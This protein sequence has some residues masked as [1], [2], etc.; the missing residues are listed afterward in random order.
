MR[1]RYY[2]SA[3]VSFCL[4]S[5]I[6]ILSMVSMYSEENKV[7]VIKENA[8]LKLKPS[9]ESLTI[10]RLPLG[11]EL[12]VVETIGEWIKIKLPPDEDGIV[13]T[14]YIH[15]SFVTFDIRPPQS[16]EDKRPTQLKEITKPYQVI[17]KP[18]A[19]FALGG[20]I[21]NIVGE[22]SQYWNTGFSVGING[23]GYLSRNILLGAHFATSRW[24]PDKNELIRDL[25]KVGIDW[26][27][28]GE[29][30]IMEIVP[31]VRLLGPWTETQSIN[32]F[33]QVGFGYYFI[34]L[35]ASVKGSYMGVTYQESIEETENKPGFTMGGGIILGRKGGFCLEI[36]PLYRIIFT[37]GGNTKYISVSV[38]FGK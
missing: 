9:D 21:S 2:K 20:G 24:T 10:K 18:K 28:S 5:M 13:V 6:L 7:R 31:S 12:A 32:V 4:F 22:G 27:F 26:D 34:N 11:S 30:T 17:S 3:F 25:P 38:L 15:S 23:F 35:D 16:M 37:E 19:S 33:A 36:L 8:V 14:G 29:A 1:S